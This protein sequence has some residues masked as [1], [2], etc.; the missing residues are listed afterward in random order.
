MASFGTDTYPLKNSYILDSGSTIHITNDRT[1]LYNFREATTADYL[2]AGNSRVWIKGYGTISLHVA[3]PQGVTALVLRDVAYCPDILCNLVSFR[4]LRTHGIWWDNRR[5]PTTLRRSDQS[6]ITELKEE[7][8][9]WVIPFTDAPSAFVAR[10]YFRRKHTS[11]TKRLKSKAPAMKWHRRLGHPGPAA[12]E[13]LMLQ[14]EGVRVN[15]IST[16]ECDACGTAKLKRQIRKAKRV[17]TQGPGERLALDFHSYEEEV[18]TKVKSQMLVTDRYSGFTWDFYFTDNRLAKSII[19][20]LKLLLTFLKIHYGIK[21][22]V[23]ECD[24]EITITKPKV[25]QWCASQGITLEPSAP[26]TQ[27]QNGGAER[28]GGVIKDKARAM[29]LDAHLP[30]Q[31]WPEITRAATYLYNRTPRRSNNWKSPYELFFTTALLYKGVVTEPRKPNLSHLKVYGCKAFALSDDT[32]RGKMKLQRLDPRAWI[33]YLVGYLS[34]NIYRI[35]IPSM[36]KTISTRDVIFNEDIVFD[37]KEDS[38]MNNLM[39]STIDDIA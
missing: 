36:G 38:I 5:D 21:V 23:I 9:Q 13:H 34:S 15:G 27:A 29:R 33:G 22:Q 30:W 1:R 2:W 24:N 12:I 6:A 39:H 17:N 4:Q 3:G 25:A 11:N 32:L 28:S 35:W 8:N 37:G 14:A 16:I 18:T 10:K 7:H 19:E 31:H 20:K 26:D